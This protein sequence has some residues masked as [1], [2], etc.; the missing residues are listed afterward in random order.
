MRFPLIGHGSWRL[1]LRAGAESFAGTAEISLDGAPIAVIAAGP[2]GRGL[3]WIDCGT[4][5]FEP[6][7]PH[8][9]EVRIPGRGVIVSGLLAVPEDDYAAA[10]AQVAALSKG[11]ARFVIEAEEA[12]A[13][14]VVPMAPK[15]FVPLLAAGAKVTRSSENARIDLADPRGA[16]VVAVE[17]ESPGEVVYTVRFPEPVAAVTLESYPRLF[18]DKVVESYV[19]ASVSVDGGP[20]TLLYRIEGS[21]DDRWEDVYKRK[22]VSEIKGPATTVTIRFAMRQAQLTSQVNAP[23]QP[24]RLVAETPVPGGAVLSFGAAARLPV[25]LDLPVP[26]AG[27]YQARLRLVGRAGQTVILPDGRPVVLPRAG[28]IVIEAGLVTPGTT[29]TADATGVLHLVLDGP[30]DVACDAVELVTRDALAYSRINAGR[31]GLTLPRDGGYLIFSEAFHPGWLLTV[32]GKALDPAKGLGFLNLYA[33]PPGA[34]GPAELLYRDE[35]L[36]AWL[37]PVMHGAWIVLI[38]AAL[39]LFVP[40]VLPGRPK[41]APGD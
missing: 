40:D 8:D 3:D 11:D 37:V 28:A 12:S 39:A 25:Q 30:V 16:G 17:G 22:V 21:H 35:A 10:L 32:S 20:F 4:A 5:T 18:G 13:G 26:L 29:G 33:L 15:L 36:M 23:N 41:A 14:P 6:G 38:L 27:R 34:S 24:M 9:V 1:F 31:Y 7:P 2:L 19:A